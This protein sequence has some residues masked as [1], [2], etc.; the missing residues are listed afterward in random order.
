MPALASLRQRH[1]KLLIDIDT[2]ANRI[3]RLGE[4]VDAAIA[5]TEGVADK[6]YSRI[7]ERGRI[8]AIG[9]R[10]LLG[11]QSSSFDP[12][13]LRSLP[14]LL[15]RDMPAAFDEWK[16]S[17]GRRE[18][19]AASI[20]YFDAGQLILDAAAE[21]LGIAFMLESHLASS[22][23]SRLVRVFPQSAESPYAYWFACPPASL[24]RPG[25]RVFHDWLFN[26]FGE[27]AKAA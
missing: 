17:V 26:H 23:D 27:V 7:L 19:E 13:G 8:I 24:A 6:H 2:G 16:Q 14:V 20:S 18:L 3:S 21:G 12:S 10:D 9:S 4:E 25:V 1:P 22:S 11:N 15:H 5:I